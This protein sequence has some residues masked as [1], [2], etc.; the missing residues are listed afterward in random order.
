[1]AKKP[2]QVNVQIN[3][4]QL[5]LHSKAY[6]TRIGCVPCPILGEDV[7][8]TAEGYFHLINESNSRPGKTNPRKP[9]EQYMKLMYLQH[10]K[11]VL[12]YSTYIDERRVTRK[13]VKGK[14][15]KVIQTEVIHEIKGEK[16]SVIVEKVGHS[17]SKFLSVFPTNKRKNTP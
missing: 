15:K 17:N 8:F 1:M 3:L 13:K 2:I 10:A 16:I 9:T 11:T 4:A 6:Y 7:H 14:W 5:K 12:K